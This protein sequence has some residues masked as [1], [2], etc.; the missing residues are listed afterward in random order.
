MRKFTLVATA[1]LFGLFLLQGT[2]RAQTL[3]AAFG[4]GA[5]SAPSASSATGSYF[6]QSV[7]GGAFP[8]FSAD[9][10]FIGNQLGVGFNVAWRGNQSLYQSFQPFRPIFYDFNAVWV[11]PLSKKVKPELYAGIGAESIRFY[12]PYLTCSFVSCTNYVSSNHFMGDVGGGLRLY[13]W[14]HF[15]VRPEAQVF[16]IR[17]NV[18]FSSFHATRYGVSI[19]YTFG[20][21]E[22]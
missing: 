11:P 14:G 20:G 16:L 3:D 12:T 19:G 13:V 10:L 15:F 22:Y 4:V 21:S 6:P 1:C 9:F 18:E 2:A 7:R 8:D 17:N 5:L